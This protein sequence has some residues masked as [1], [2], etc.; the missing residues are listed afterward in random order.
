MAQIAMWLLPPH[1]GNR[2]RIYLLRLCGFRIGRGTV[3]W[4]APTITGSGNLYRRLTIGEACW[5]NTD[6]FF[7]VGADIWIGDRVAIG[8]QVLI[9]TETHAI[10]DSTCR[11]GMLRAAPVSIGNGVW[12]GARCTILPGVT[13]G[14]GAIVA[15]GAVVTKTVS[16]N[17]LVGGIPARLLRELPAD[18][19]QR[20]NILAD[21]KTSV[22][23]E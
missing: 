10:G 13:I 7:N 1:V 22:L 12:L 4:G 20:A 2:L 15:A 8:H 21:L 11:A 17:T 6:C 9:L 14:E 23:V 3:M 16:P 19:L 18:N 5:I